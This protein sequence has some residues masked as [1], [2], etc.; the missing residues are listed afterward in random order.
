MIAHV[1]S[2]LAGAKTIS[3][4]CA[5]FTGVTLFS[6]SLCLCVSVVKNENRA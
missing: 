1:N 6:L 3:G 4:V 2:E 5:F